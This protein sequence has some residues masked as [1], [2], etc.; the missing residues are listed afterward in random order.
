MLTAASGP[1][2]GQ[3][4]RA[5][6]R[7]LV[8]SLRPAGA[9]RTQARRLWLAGAWLLLSLLLVL[10]VLPSPPPEVRLFSD[11]W[12][13]SS[14]VEGE[15]CAPG[16]AAQSAAES[17]RP[18]PP[19]QASVEDRLALAARYLA[20]GVLLP[21][22][23]PA[24][25]LSRATRQRHAGA[26][27]VFLFGVAPAYFQWAANPGFVSL[28][29][30]MAEYWLERWP[31]EAE[32]LA[33]LDA[34]A[35]SAWMLGGLSVGLL[36]WGLLAAGA[37]LSATSGARAVAVALPMGIALL[38]LG[39]TEPTVAYLR[40]EGL[41]L[42]A[43]PV[44]RGG[45]LVGAVLTSVAFALRLYRREQCSRPGVLLLAAWSLALALGLA[46]G[47]AMYFHWVDRY[48]V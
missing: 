47:W 43:L 22:L 14:F 38:V 32:Y 19:V 39:L 48:R 42:G 11:G 7:R 1:V 34:A 12:G 13:A 45:V 35:V 33:W 17:L 44:L 4:H 5:S 18:K 21:L 31:M 27:L 25:L 28:R 2:T 37:R 23:L 46:H 16:E 29:Q 20:L 15:A 9:A 10:A 40:G 41:V 36:I 6:V 24:A 30:A 26:L 8:A 3:P